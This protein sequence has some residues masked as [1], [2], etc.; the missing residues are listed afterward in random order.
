MLQG[1]RILDFTQYL[2]GP[3]ATH[4]LADM[5]A[6]VIK[7][8]APFGDPARFSLD[9]NEQSP[10]FLAQNRKK[11]SV[12]L[13]LKDSS[14]RE[15]ALELA[16]EADILIEGFRPGV[17]SRIGI[18]YDEIKQVNPEIIYCSLTGYGQTGPLSHLG[19]HDINYMAL[20]GMLAQM[21]DENGKPHLP[22]NT[23]ADFIGGISA[24]EAILAA[25]VKKM[26][27]G[28]GSYI[29]LAITKSLLPLMS[30]HVLIESL[31]GEKH[32]VE[33]L[34]SVFVCYTLYE[35][36]DHRYI[37][38]G[39]LEQK[40][41]HNFCD[42]LGREDW[43]SKQFSKASPGDPVYEEISA[44]IKEKTIKEWSQFALKV[45]CC[46]APV[47]ESDDL[48][49]ADGLKEWNLISDNGSYRYMANQFTGLSEST[50]DTEPPALGAH[51]K[52]CLSKFTHGGS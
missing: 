6:E 28:A 18:G 19:G 3:H 41:W 8:E 24:S 10:V 50:R 46:M 38:L 52:E 22:S 27:T 2:P 39:A 40:F 33:K 36:A 49:Y 45:D 4:R 37:S 31:T 35:T 11:K 34:N 51:T 42:A 29:D 5:G 30:N 43:K 1:I 23:L 21:K 9:E 44:A 20:S 48:A 25:L 47:L 14:D 16:R 15:S 17:A 32:G 12:V 26:Q 7:I 13:N